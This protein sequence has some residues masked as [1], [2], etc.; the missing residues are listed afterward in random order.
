ML[1][2]SQTAV[3]W[4]ALTHIHQPHTSCGLVNRLHIHG[5]AVSTWHKEQRFPLEAHGA[6]VSTYVLRGNLYMSRHVIL[7][8]LVYTQPKISEWQKSNSSFFFLFCF[9]L[10]FFFFADVLTKWKL[11]TLTMITLLAFVRNAMFTDVIF[12]YHTNVVLACVRLHCPLTVS[13]CVLNI[14][15][16]LFVN[17][18]H[19]P[20][21]RF[22][23]RN[24]LFERLCMKCNIYSV[25]FFGTWCT[26]YWFAS[27]CY[28]WHAD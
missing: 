25:R 24:A 2:T 9:C 5:A 16:L 28:S 18:V 6:A 22:I 10:L 26:F 23:A 1:C 14:Y 12:W 20:T 4:F 15:M 17:H 21:P 19:L 11:T 27:L 3:L 8:K 7:F 13:L